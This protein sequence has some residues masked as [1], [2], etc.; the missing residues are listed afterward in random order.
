VQ[1]GNVVLRS[2][3]SEA[4]LVRDVS[5]LLASTFGFEI[6]VIARTGTQLADVA[7]HNPFVGRASE[8]NRQLHVAF[9]DRAPAAAAAARLDP[10]RAL[11]EELLVRKREVYLWCPNGLGRSKV[12]TGAEKLLGTAATVRNW[13]TVNELLRLTG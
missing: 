4:T 13:Q 2:R 9:L 7:S 11:P 12:F 10:K 8:P 3:A 1:S 6:P 5:A